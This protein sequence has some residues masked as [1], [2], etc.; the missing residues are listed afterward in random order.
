MAEL[1][2]LH[3]PGYKYC[4]SIYAAVN[5]VVEHFKFDSRHFGPP[6][7]FPGSNYHGPELAIKRKRHLA[8]SIPK[9]L[10]PQVST[11]RGRYAVHM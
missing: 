5:T 8:M 1:E 6:G 11:E 4:G 3:L 7:T 2:P 9:P 10:W